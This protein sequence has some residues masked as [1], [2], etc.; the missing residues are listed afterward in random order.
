MHLHLAR[1]MADLMVA[2]TAFRAVEAENRHGGPP[3]IQGLS[4]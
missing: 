3:E 1:Q 4:R 2:E